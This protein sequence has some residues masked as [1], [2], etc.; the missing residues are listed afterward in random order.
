MVLRLL[1]QPRP[2]AAA[3]EGYA[4]CALSR[5]DGARLCREGRISASMAHLR[6]PARGLR[7]I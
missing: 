4:H 5:L 7:M 1:L 2:D 3:K 6:R